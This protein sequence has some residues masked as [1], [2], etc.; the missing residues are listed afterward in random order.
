VKKANAFKEGSWKKYMEQVGATK[1]DPF[2]K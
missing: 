1:M 2:G